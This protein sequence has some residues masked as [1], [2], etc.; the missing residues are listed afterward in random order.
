MAGLDTLLQLLSGQTPMAATAAPMAGGDV[1]GALAGGAGNQPALA[2]AIQSL[3]SK[4]RM[5][6]Q[7]AALSGGAPRLPGAQATTP[8]PQAAPVDV[9]PRITNNTAAAAPAA[10]ASAPRLDFSK[11]GDFLGD[12]AAGVPANPASGLASFATGFSGARQSAGTRAQS[13]AKAELDAE[14]RKTAAEDR[15]FKRQM[16]TRAANRADQTAGLNALLTKARIKQIEDKGGIKQMTAKDLIDIERLAVGDYAKDL[17]LTTDN[18][19][20]GKQ[21]DEA[22]AKVDAYRTDLQNRFRTALETGG[23]G[24]E[25][26]GA[27]D[28]TGADVEAEPPASGSA[29]PAAAPVA[30]PPRAVNPTTGEAVIWNGSAWVPE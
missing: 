19:L 8:A 29:A 2:A 7:P 22:M 15:T 10:P 25:A 1:G 11:F 16:D 27:P 26:A 20:F 21:R 6:S 13:Q 12:A 23:S 14:E 17:G 9:R 4:A 5:G 24:S 18:A 3:L 30:N 28:M